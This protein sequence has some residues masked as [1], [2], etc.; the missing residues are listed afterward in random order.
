M[1]PDSYRTTPARLAIRS[2]LLHGASL[3]AIATLLERG[4]LFLANVLSARIAGAENYGAY[5]LA[6]Q[7]AG[8]LASQASLGIGMVATRFAAEYPVGHPQNRAFVLRIIQLS[9]CLALAASFLM[10]ICVW[11]LAH[12]FYN[13]PLFFRVLLV[14]VFTAPM[15]VMLDAARGLMLGLSYY[16]G[17]VMLSSIF[18][19]TMLLLM[20]WAAME[21]PGWMVF[22][23]AVSALSACI[24]I[25]WLLHH[26][27]N[28]NLFSRI[29]SDVP[30][31][32]ML[33]FGLLQLGTSTAV[34]LVMIAMMALLVR[35]ASREEL[36][37]TSL[38]P[39]GFALQQ[40]V[41]WM[42]NYALSVY[43]FFGFRE[44]GYYNAASS[45]RNITGILPS[46]LNQATISLMTRL[47]GEPYGGVNR[48]VLINTWLSAMYM[49]PVTC[50]GLIL[51]PWLLPFFF[52]KDFVEGVYPA[53]YLLV[54]ALIH[55]VSQPAV[56]QL[57]IL[58][59]RVI[60][61]IHMAWIVVALLSAWFLVPGQGAA[62]VALA[63][64][65]AH[66]AAAM[67]VPLALE[68]LGQV[69][70]QLFTMTMAG[71]L[72]GLLPLLLL[73]YRQ[74][75]LFHWSNAAALLVCFSVMCG[76]W[77]Q[78]RKLRTGA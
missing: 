55:M 64:I 47:R 67:L 36:I 15:F 12:W 4:F 41:M 33:R 3:I 66:A 57:T 58:R 10:L 73:D 52:G 71:M 45:I 27:F 75:S 7:T 53:S 72:G 20:P 14:T 8:F 62:G 54:V 59:P 40:G 17:L 78:G 30:V 22:A 28:I 19:L 46:L 13:K 25:L 6:L 44:V 60:M 63:L 42:T 11:P 56:N 51:L 24:V 69:P 50:L 16:R 35:Y 26:H 23:H 61:F 32:P 31:K 9:V 21:G 29:A 1:L 34:N 70:P 65:L 48:V 5:G 74:P 49:L 2:F 68:Y 39:L 18:G 77:T 37:A 76:I 43:P 38:L